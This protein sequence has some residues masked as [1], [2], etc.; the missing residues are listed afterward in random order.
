MTTNL[1]TE[2]SLQAYRQ[3]SLNYWTQHDF[4][5][6]NTVTLGIDIGME[7]IG[8]AV[9]KGTELLYCKTLMVDLPEAKALAARRALRASRHARKNRRTRMRRLQALFARHGLPWVDDDIMSRSDPFRLRHR[10]ITGRLASKE[11]LSICIRSCV[12]RRGYDYFAMDDDSS[13]EYPWGAG[14]EMKDAQKWLQSAYVDAEMR[15]YLLQLTDSLTEDEKKQDAWIQLVEARHSKA[16]QEGIPSMLEA[17]YHKHLNER[18]ARGFNYPRAHVQNHLQCIIDRHADL[19]DDAAGFSA[20]LFCPNDT[21][22]NKKQAIFLY[23]RKTPEE[24]KRVFERKVK[25]CPYCQWLEI[26][27]VRCCT[28]GELSYRRWALVDFLSVRKFE[29]KAGKIPMGRIK[30]PE[31]TVKALFDAMESGLTKWS[32]AKKLMTDALKQDKLSLA[33]GDWNKGQ[34]EQ[35]KDIVTP[36]AIARKGRTSMSAPAAQKMYEAATQGGTCFSPDAMEQWKQDSGLYHFRKSMPTEGGIYPQV[37]TLL[38]Y[39]KAQHIKATADSPAHIVETLKTTG[40]L[41]RIFTRD[42]KDRLGGK[43]VPDYCVV[44]TIKNAAINQDKAKEIEKEQKE[45][46]ARREKLAKAYNR[47]N[48]SNAD[49]MRMRLFA[50]QGG[51]PTHS[52]RCPF[53]GQ[54]LSPSILFSGEL[55]LAHIYPDSRGGLYMVENLVLT[56]R[57]VNA[58]MGNRTP[59]EAAAAHLPG[60]KSW[61]EILKMTKNFNWHDEKR[62]LFAHDKPEFPEF[63]N[64]TRTAQLA[65]EL[66]TSL[67]AWLQISGNEEQIRRRIGNPCGVYTAAARRSWL[68]PEYKKDRANNLHHRLDA[69][70]MSCLPPEGLNDI[71]YKGIF[72]TEKTAKGDRRLMCIQGLPL[73]DFYKMWH[74]G[75]VSPVEKKESTSK[76]KSLGDSTFWSVDKEG[77]THQRT[78]LAADTKMSAAEIRKTLEKMGI[79]AKDIPSDAEITRWLTQAQAASKAEENTPIPPLKL[80]NGTPVRNIWKF[81]SKGNLDRSPIGW[82]GIITES[83][84]FDQLRSLSSSNDRLEL[85]L[86][87]NAKKKCWEYYK[88]II[89]TKA[90]LAGFKRMGLPWRGT[91]NAPQYLLNILQKNKA[92]DLHEM[93]CGILPPHS[94]KVAT[95][96]KGDIFN[97]SFDRDDKYIE[98]LQKKGSV[99]MLA[100]PTPIQTWGRV[101]AIKSSKFIEIKAVTHKDRKPREIG[102]PNALATLKNLSDAFEQA[103]V[104]NLYPQP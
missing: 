78:P 27:V 72:E 103:S 52:A 53:T 28:A 62:K 88:R 98:K 58:E 12:L 82:N 70:V 77:F 81:G 73:P 47:T 41:Q 89:P 42:L 57:K 22:E 94:I 2:T 101:S 3:T 90:V 56:T 45:N 14:L 19:I 61:E 97:L 5:A 11:A 20:A 40:F 33:T 9:R 23:N 71:R 75:S 64:I 87:W 102:N 24:A 16:A 91:K 80:R 76:Y 51:S 79:P 49:F 65:R 4:F 68:W 60:W 85:W 6:P 13:G 95:F 1:S 43:T 63:N 96:K 93:I 104:L 92:R 44:E 67:A 99:D 86:G 37:E 84:K 59:V 50:E 74:D 21:P 30:L 39:R 36:S 69:A 26:P 29:L 100:H 83:D 10:A 34:L 7:G 35:L 17:Y 31:P 66:R 15:Q 55:E 25:K 8:I 48:A 38:G 32:D 54:E 46:R 18:K